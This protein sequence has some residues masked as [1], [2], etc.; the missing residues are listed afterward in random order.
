MPLLLPPLFLEMLATGMDCAISISGGKDSQ[1]M[2]LTFVAWFRAQGF[3]GKLYALHTTL[4][5]AERSETP[6]FLE[7]LCARIALP[8]IVVQPIV[9]GQP[10]DLQDS[11]ERR[12]LQLAGTNT[13]A[14]PSMRN[15]YCTALKVSACEKEM[16]KS[17]LIA[18]IEG[19]RAAE[20]EPRAEKDPFTIREKIT[21]ERYKHLALEA[22]WALYQENAQ[23]R[24]GQYLFFEAPVQAR[25]LPRLA[26]TLYPLFFWSEEAVWRACG[27]STQ[28]LEERR[29]LYLQGIERE[30]PALR[31]QA[32]A[33]WCAHP[34]YVKGARR[35][36][37]SLCIWADRETLRSGAYDS[38]SYYRQLVWMEIES[39]FPFQQRLW[40][41]EVAP[42]LLTDEQHQALA[43][44]PR[45][46][47][48]LSRTRRS[49]VLPLSGSAAHS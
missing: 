1:A 12:H 7:A 34:A 29:A 41:A 23:T 32:L 25:P 19:I 47:R 37:C 8:L 6:G 13:P 18:S 49:T 5:R 35:L 40:L 44:L 31:A 21:G 45:Y 33:G 30:D 2:L 48:W 24:D 16:R 17:L 43:A 46:Q 22:A 28:A 14:W 11:L 20:S 38:P 4:G 39:G 15:R 27:T 9:G 26:V 10:G 42:E 3:T 36:S